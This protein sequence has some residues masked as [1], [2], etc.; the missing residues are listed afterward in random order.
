MCAIT[1]LIKGP[2]TTLV[3]F[4]RWCLEE[5]ETPRPQ[6]MISF[7]D[8]QPRLTRS[9]H[10]ATTRPGLGRGVVPAYPITLT[11]TGVPMPCFYLTPQTRRLQQLLYEVQPTPRPGSYLSF[12]RRSPG[13]WWRIANPSGSFVLSFTQAT[14]TCSCFRSSSPASSSIQKP[15]P[16]GATRD[17][18]ATSR[19]GG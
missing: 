12:L 17:S 14:S 1:R 6:R 13:H 11:K 5:A 8:R 15:H 18:A 16:G 4:S 10:S 3:E 2:Q 7:P 9:S 19:P